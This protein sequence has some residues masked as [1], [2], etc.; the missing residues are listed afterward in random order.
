MKK[1]IWHNNMIH[2]VTKKKFFTIPWSKVPLSLPAPKREC[3]IFGLSMMKNCV[4]NMGI[5]R[6]TSEH[7]FATLAFGSGGNSHV[8]WTGHFF[9][10][11][12]V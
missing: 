2:K 7:M 1:I 5:K 6:A 9:T 4:R 12:I 10:S 11:L 3:G 8:L